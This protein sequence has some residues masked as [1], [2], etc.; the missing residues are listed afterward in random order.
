MLLKFRMGAGNLGRLPSRGELGLVSVG[1]LEVGLTVE[2]DRDEPSEE[3][4]DCTS[5]MPGGLY[6]SNKGPLQRFTLCQEPAKQAR[7]SYLSLVP[8]WWWRYHYC[9][10]L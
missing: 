1:S 5:P 4:G 6:H 3:C 7:P 9:P 8:T 2:G 10:I